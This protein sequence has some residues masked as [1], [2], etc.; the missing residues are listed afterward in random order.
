MSLINKGFFIYKNCIS[1]DLIKEL[2][3]S[4]L[5]DLKDITKIKTDN[6]N[7]ID[8]LFL[9]AINTYHQFD[10]QSYLHHG[11]QHRGL[12]ERVLKEIKILNFCKKILGNDLAYNED[13]SLVANVKGA[14]DNLYQKN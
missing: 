11:L 10:V 9:K 1:K 8:K 13:G 7:D 14:K 2:K 5:A 6:I 12:K 4:F 3:I